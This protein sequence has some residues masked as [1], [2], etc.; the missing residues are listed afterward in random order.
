MGSLARH[1]LSA[2][3]YSV[4]GP[5]FPYGILTVNVLGGLIMGIIVELGALM[6]A[7]NGE[8]RFAPK[9]WAS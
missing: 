8:A 5:A 4:T 7:V 6:L 9:T 2:G 3:V 1:Y